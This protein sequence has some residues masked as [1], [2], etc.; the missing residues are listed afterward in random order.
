MSTYDPAWMFWVQMIPVFTIWLLAIE[1][2]QDE[3]PYFPF[4]LFAVGIVGMWAAL[5]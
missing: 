3:N 4:I 1:A 2:L 5:T